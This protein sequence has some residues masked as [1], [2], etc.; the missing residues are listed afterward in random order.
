MIRLQYG[1]HNMK[2]IDLNK[3]QIEQIENGLDEYDNQN[4][5]HP[6]G[7][8]IYIGIEEDN[9]LIAGLIADVTAFKIL[10]VSTVFVEEA[11]RKKGYGKKLIQ[12]MERRAKELGVT[13][14][15]IDTFG[16]QGSGFYESVGYEVVGSYEVKEEGY[17]EYF[18]IKRI[19]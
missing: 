5:L 19:K 18:Y 16:F 12:E 9:K 6:L 13:V 11:Y 3:K 8:H 14:I 15:R 4:I 17:S 7:G 1:F 10:Y 2:I